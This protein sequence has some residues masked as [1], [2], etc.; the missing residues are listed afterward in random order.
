MTELKEL[1]RSWRDAYGSVVALIASGMSPK[2][3]QVGMRESAAKQAEARFDSS[4]ADAQAEIARLRGALEKVEQLAKWD[5]NDLPDADS[6]MQQTWRDGYE[7]AIEN[8]REA[9]K[10]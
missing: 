5:Q 7:Y 10:K 9:L 4:L 3:K 6:G 2:S 8:L 1:A